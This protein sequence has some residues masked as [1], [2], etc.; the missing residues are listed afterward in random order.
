MRRRDF[1]RAGSALA[2]AASFGTLALTGRRASAQ[3][4]GEPLE[5]GSASALLPPGK[6]AEG[7]LEC[8]LYGGLSLWESFYGVKEYGTS[9]DPAKELQNTQLYTFF[10]AGN[11]ALVKALTGCGGSA[12]VLGS[13]V[14]FAKDALGAQVHMGPLAA[15]YLQ[16]PDLVA[17]TRLVVN[18]HDLEPHE[19]AIPYAMTGR[20]L[21]APT[22]SSI[23]AH[24]QRY[25]LEHDD[26]GRRSPHSYVFT[27]QLGAG[28]TDNIRA[29]SASGVH[30]GAARPLLSKVDGAAR[31][32][33]LLQRK[34]VGEGR[35]EYDALLE[36]YVDQYRDRLRF[37]KAGDPLRAP[38]LAELSQ[39]AASVKNADA[40]ASVLDPK[41]FEQIKDT[42]C[43]DTDV[44][45]PAMALRLAT[46][47]LTHPTE[48]ARHC[49]IIDPG[50]KE[51]DGGG[52][53]DTHAENCHTQARNFS[54]FLTYLLANIN[55]PGEKNPQKIDLDKTMVVL[56]MEF[57]RSPGR[58]PP[59]GRNHWPYGYVQIYIGGPIG[60]AQKGI[61]GAIGP[62]GY[63]PEGM[64][65]T[66]S[67]N[68]IACLLALGIWP[69][70]P[71]SY[72]V[73]DVVGAQNE[74]DGVKKVSER[75]LGHAE[76]GS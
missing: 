38:K 6:R 2:A 73:S 74:L 16:R 8:F 52:G 17:R 3:P 19:A 51:A 43:G 22:M 25:F 13:L 34:T 76:V 66:P 49:T 62:D 14:P 10:N 63:A 4:F 71:D 55:A 7:I 61:F 53:Y 28:A 37:G 12:D 72:G 59:Q 36:A 65:T 67:E 68:R 1:V 31:L 64:Y 33:D 39:G 40:V 9:N 54:N 45:R 15:L 32:V 46:R 44:N 60:A 70:N 48:P 30:P 23:G 26:S 41:L 35:P 56:N 50:L 75:V 57:G 42:I 47:M 29:A 24:V 27:S 11:Q 21:G 5:S 20:R 69:F 58:Q 18:R